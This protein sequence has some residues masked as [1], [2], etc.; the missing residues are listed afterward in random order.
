MIAIPVIVPLLLHCKISYYSCTI[1]AAPRS[2]E[3]CLKQQVTGSELQEQ[4]TGIV[5]CR[6]LVGCICCN[7]LEFKHAQRVVRRNNIEIMSLIALEKYGST[8]RGRPLF[9]LSSTGL[10]EIDRS[11]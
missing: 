8:F 11:I 9:S 5:C 2:V 7:Y 3:L 10:I 4:Q 6:Y 1:L